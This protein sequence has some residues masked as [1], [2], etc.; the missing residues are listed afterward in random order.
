MSRGPG[1][2]RERL[3]CRPVSGGRRTW[4]C[5]ARPGREQVP[6]PEGRVCLPAPPPATGMQPPFNTQTD[7]AF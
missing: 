5:V 7:M 6:R 1:C 2:T 4:V 3:P